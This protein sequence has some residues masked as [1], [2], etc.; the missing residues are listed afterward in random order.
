MQVEELSTDD[1]DGSMASGNSI[2]IPSGIGLATCSK[3]V[4]GWN[5]AGTVDISSTDIGGASSVMT[6]D[7]LGVAG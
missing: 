6:G 1:S 3:S 2:P 7:L 4:A 5:D